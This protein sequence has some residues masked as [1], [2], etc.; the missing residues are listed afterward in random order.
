MKQENYEAL[1]R[2]LDYVRQH[3]NH[4]ERRF[5][6]SDREDRD[7][8]QIYGWLDEEAKKNPKLKET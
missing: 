6:N 7:F 3:I 4:L 2:L 8:E 1:R 5:L